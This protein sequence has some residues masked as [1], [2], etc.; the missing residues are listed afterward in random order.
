MSIQYIIY[1]HNYIQSGT[2]QKDRQVDHHLQI[3]IRKFFGQR[4]EYI[5]I[6]IMNGKI[7]LEMI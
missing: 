3:V 2:G 6:S 1:I 7:T 5:A 4:Q